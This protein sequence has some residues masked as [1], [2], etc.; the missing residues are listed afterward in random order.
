MS[1]TSVLDTHRGSVAPVRKGRESNMFG[2]RTIRRH[3]I[4]AT[5]VLLVSMGV[6]T[7]SLGVATAPAQAQ[8][9]HNSYMSDSE[10][11]SVPYVPGD[12]SGFAVNK[13]ETVQMQCWSGGPKAMG[14]Y[15]WFEITVL[16]SYHYGLSGEVPAPSVGDQWTSSPEC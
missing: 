7:V 8:A 6:G 13:G 2:N 1:A 5:A 14:Q 11:V 16:S 12:C 10:C 9:Q 3:R 15:K 4:G